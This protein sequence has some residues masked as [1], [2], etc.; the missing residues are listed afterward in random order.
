MVS[1]VNIVFVFRALQAG[2]GWKL[3]VL[4]VI[5]ITTTQRPEVEYLFFYPSIVNC[6][7]L[8]V[9][10][11]F[12]TLCLPYLTETSWA[13]PAGFPSIVPPGTEVTRKVESQE[14]P[15]TPHPGGEEEAS[16]EAAV[17]L[18]AEVPEQESQL[19]KTTKISFRVRG[20]LANI[21]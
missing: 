11:D 16:S 15:S 21:N 3:S 8:V 2:V 9:P 20:V 19:S 4:M 7:T 17:P 18:E 10:F 13:N 5:N 1:Y 12:H 14:K 6:K